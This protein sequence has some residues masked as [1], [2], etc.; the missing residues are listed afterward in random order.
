MGYISQLWPFR[1]P[2]ENDNREAD[3]LIISVVAHF[4]SCPKFSM[5]GLCI[6]PAALCME[7]GVYLLELHPL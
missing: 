7:T 6:K 4:V 3:Y 2:S 1:R 5:Q